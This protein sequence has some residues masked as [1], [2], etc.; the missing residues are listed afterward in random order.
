MLY[1]SAAVLIPFALVVVFHDAL[2]RGITM[3][4]VQQVP[5][6][7]VQFDGPF[8]LSHI[9]PLTLDAKGVRIAFNDGELAGIRSR[10]DTLHLEMHL[11]PLLRGIA[12]HRTIEYR[13][14]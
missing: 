3:R 4:L 10:F 8:D 1:A 6:V 2:A 9:A 5:G 7:E 13:R 11:W 14:R 12:P